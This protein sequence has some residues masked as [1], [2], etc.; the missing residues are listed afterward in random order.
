[1][2][3]AELVRKGRRAGPLNHMV[4][5]VPSLVVDAS[6]AVKWSCRMKSTP[7]VPRQAWAQFRG[8]SGIDQGGSTLSNSTAT[9][10]I[11]DHRESPS[12]TLLYYRT[13][14]PSAVTS[15]RDHVPLNHSP[16]RPELHIDEDAGGRIEPGL[17]D[18]SHGQS[19]RTS[20]EPT[21]L[22]IIVA[23][24]ARLARPVNEP[25]SVPA[26]DTQVPKCGH[27]LADNAQRDPDQP[28][29]SPGFLAKSRLPL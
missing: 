6:V 2:T 11:S 14:S 8:M 18:Q 28:C 29:C 10:R 13:V 21:C 4:P 19:S 15:E 23:A 3:T 25:A 12:L 16:R 1:M 17:G 26:C 20:S 5:A 24:P 22:V 7:T 9:S 27:V